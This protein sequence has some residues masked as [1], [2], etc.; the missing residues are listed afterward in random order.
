MPF[1]CTPFCVSPSFRLRHRRPKS[2]IASDFP[3]AP[4]KSQ[5]IIA[6]SCFGN[7]AISGVRDGH[8]N[9]KSQ[10]S[11]SPP[12]N[13]P[14]LARPRPFLARPSPGLARSSPGPRPASPVPRPTPHHHR[15]KQSSRQNGQKRNLLGVRV[16]NVCR[17]SGPKCSLKTLSK[18]RSLGTTP[19][20][21]KTLSER[22]GH[23]RSSGR[24]SCSC[25]RPNE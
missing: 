9:R 6:V 24:V 17:K 11:L 19:I 4:L 21:G 16:R 7:R 25:I 20:S 13:P 22:K 10:K 1:S 5:C 3:I 15:F 14:F 2:Q 12:C 8:R 23:S 18:L